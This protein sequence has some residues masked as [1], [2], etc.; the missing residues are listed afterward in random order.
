MIFS[1]RF[2]G[3]GG[4]KVPILHFSGDRGNEA[5]SSHSTHKPGPSS[6]HA[7]QIPSNAARLQTELDAS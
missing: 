7:G 3:L 1:L 6:R 4:V 2:Y 5:E